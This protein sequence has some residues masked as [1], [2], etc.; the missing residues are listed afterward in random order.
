VYADTCKIY[1]TFMIGEDGTTQTAT[2]VQQEREAF[3][4]VTVL[5]G[6]KDP[7]PGEHGDNHLLKPK[8][9]AMFKFASEHFEWATHYGKVDIDSMPHL[10]VALDHISATSSSRDSPYKSLV[11]HAIE[12]HEVPPDWAEELG[13][14]YFGWLNRFD[15]SY[16]EGTHAY[17]GDRGFQQGQFYIISAG[18]MRCVIKWVRAN[19]GGSLTHCTDLPGEDQMV[20][21]MILEATGQRFENDAPAFCPQPVYINM[22]EE[23]KYGPSQSGHAHPIQWRVS[24]F[25][26]KASDD[27]AGHDTKD[28]F[29]DWAELS[30]KMTVLPEI[31]TTTCNGFIRNNIMCAEAAWTAKELSKSS[32]ATLTVKEIFA[33]I[34]QEE[35]DRAYAANHFDPSVTTSGE[36]CAGDMYAT[37][38]GNW[39]ECLPGTWTV[40]RS[41][42]YVRRD[43]H[44]RPG[45]WTEYAYNKAQIRT[46]TC[47]PI[48]ENKNAGENIAPPAASSPRFAGTEAECA[49][50]VAQVDARIKKA[51]ARAAKLEKAIGKL[52]TLA[53]APITDDDDIL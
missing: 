15:P 38:N 37:L 43:W 2:R 10:Q 24:P 36:G 23:L 13:G 50:A 18:L 20:G 52:R 19:E 48:P 1:Y 27:G 22:R 51:N 35:T 40:D 30:G 42:V 9:K 21:C 11:N 6:S 4:D 7:A 31:A 8:V 16:V 46:Y 28:G 17:K 39:C 5:Q 25:G 26:K 3:G 12:S 34:K 53:S 33:N 44:T 47:T 41:G 32:R 14:T 49:D 45:G 29:S